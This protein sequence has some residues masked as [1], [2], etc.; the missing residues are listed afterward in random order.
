[1]G[2][3]IGKLRHRESSL[4][5]LGWYLHVVTSRLCVEPMAPMFP[6]IPLLGASYMWLLRNARQNRDGYPFP[7]KEQ[8]TVPGFLWFSVLQS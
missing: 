1:M 8:V 4:A 3:P 5:S 2:E 7:V 6:L